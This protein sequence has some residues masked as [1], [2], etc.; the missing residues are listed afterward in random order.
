MKIRVNV[1]KRLLLLGTLLAVASFATGCATCGGYRVC[2]VGPVASYSSCEPCA[3]PCATPCAAKYVSPYAGQYYSGDECGMTC[4]GCSSGCGDCVE[5]FRPFA[6]WCNLLSLGGNCG[7]ACEKYYGDYINNPP[8]LCNPCD[9]F[10]GLAGF[11]AKCPGGSCDPVMSTS[12]MPISQ[13]VSTPMMSPMSTGS[14]CKTCNQGNTFY[15]SQSRPQ[16]QP[17]GTPQSG[18]MMA[19]APQAT[20]PVIIAQTRAIPP[21]N[22]RPILQDKLVGSNQ[23]QTMNYRMQPIVQ[24]QMTAS[25]Q[26]VNYQTQPIRQVATNGKDNRFG[27]TNKVIQPATI[28]NNGQG[29]VHAR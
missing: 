8:S 6:R 3:V 24:N 9:Q 17:V 10:G 5:S 23:P 1:M 22:V 18:M 13:P 16:M 15:T 20:Q 2:G 28:P 27:T 12:Y 21:Q 11:S 4:G 29:V 19:R 25:Q 7:C 26:P 14:D